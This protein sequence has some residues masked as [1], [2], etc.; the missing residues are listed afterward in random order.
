[1]EQCR[2]HCVGDPPRNKAGPKGPIGFGDATD[3]L[4]LRVLFGASPSFLSPV[5][6][7]TNFECFPVQV[8][9]ASLM[10]PA[11]E[12]PADPVEND[13]HWCWLICRQF[14]LWRQACR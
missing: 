13:R 14:N 7:M 11:T 6:T 8:A 2:H 12:F 3:G 9:I 10:W 5:A 4:H 1:M